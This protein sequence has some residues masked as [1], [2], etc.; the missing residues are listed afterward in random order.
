MTPEQRARVIATLPPEAALHAER[1]AAALAAVAEKEAELRAREA[2]LRSE[3]TKH[4][5]E[6]ET[7]LAAALAESERRKKDEPR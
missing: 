7:R 1:Y 6:I 2:R 5:A 3:E 4:R